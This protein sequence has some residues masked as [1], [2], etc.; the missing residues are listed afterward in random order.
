VAALFFDGWAVL[1]RTLVIGLLAYV[2]L[3]AFLRVS[4]RP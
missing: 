2:L 3:I 1:G 4:G